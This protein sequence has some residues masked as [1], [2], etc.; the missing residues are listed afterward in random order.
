MF[1]REKTSLLGINSLLGGKGE[2]TS[3][4]Q[5]LSQLYKTKSPIKAVLSAGGPKTWEGLTVSQFLAR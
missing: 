3:L 4:S 2:R 5:S 1:L